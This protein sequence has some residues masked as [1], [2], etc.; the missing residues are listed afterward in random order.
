MH[1]CSIQ[2]NYHI[3]PSEA[4]ILSFPKLFKNCECHFVIFEEMIRDS[5][6]NP[7]CSLTRS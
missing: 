4:Y 7:R 6:A 1:M 3:T 5:V 2:L